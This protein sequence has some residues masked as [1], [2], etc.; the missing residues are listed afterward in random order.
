MIMSHMTFLDMHP[1]PINPAHLG[2]AVDRNPPLLLFDM[3]R[4]DK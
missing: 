2:E 1:F 4:A 3:N